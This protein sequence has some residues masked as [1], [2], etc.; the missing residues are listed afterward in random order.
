MTANRD[1]HRVV[2]FTA[3]RRLVAARTAIGRERNII[4]SLTEVDIREPRR[5]IREHRERTGETLSLIAYVVTCLSRALA[6]QPVLGASLPDREAGWDS[7][8]ADADAEGIEYA[9]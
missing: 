7:V 8:I 6:E 3:N 2:P 9:P 4:H 5:R 1:G